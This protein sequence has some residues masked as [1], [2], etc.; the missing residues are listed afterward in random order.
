MSLCVL[1]C[2]GTF[3]FAST[4]APT[5]S[6]VYHSDLQLLHTGVHQTSEAGSA[7]VTYARGPST[8]LPGRLAHLGR[9]TRDGE[10]VTG[11]TSVAPSG[12][13]P[14]LSKVETHTSTQDFK[15]IKMHSWS[16]FY[17][18]RSAWS[19]DQGSSDN[20]SP[21]NNVAL[22]VTKFCVMWEGQALPPD[23]KFGNCRGEIVDR[24]A[25]PSRSLINGSSWS[26]LIKVEP[27]PRNS[28]WPPYQRCGW[29][30]KW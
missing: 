9:F 14:K 27:G 24:G 16:H 21:V 5:I 1:Q 7:S 17:Q 26:G 4:N 30:F 10:F 22:T 29:R 2:R 6:C 25:F 15:F 8:C 20:H 13:D 19:V 28:T 12:M 3:S 11:H 23:T 18:T